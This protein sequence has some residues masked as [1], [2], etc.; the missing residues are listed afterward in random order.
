MKIGIDGRMIGE[1]MHGIARYTLN[2]LKGILKIDK[3]NQYVLLITDKFP[4]RQYMTFD[5]LRYIYMKSPF[6]SLSEP[7]ELYTVIRRERFELFHSPSF[8]PPFYSKQPFLMTIHDMSHLTYAGISRRLYYKFIIKPYVKKARKILTVSEFSRKEICKAFSLKDDKVSVV[9]NGV[10]D[11]FKPFGIEEINK[12]KKRYNLPDRFILSIGNEK[13]H[14]NFYLLLKAFKN[15]INDYSLVL[16]LSDKNPLIKESIKQGLGRRVIF[17]GYIDDRDLPLLYNASS[18][19]VFI[20]LN[21]GFGLPPLEAM[22]SGCPSV[23]SD[24]SSLPEICGDA[25]YYVDPYDD[26]S[27][28]TGINKTIED[29][30]LRDRLIRKGLE[31]AKLFSWEKASRKIFDFYQGNN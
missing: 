13:I 26:I 6:V 5:N 25:A 24:A 8:I 3:Y 18:V 7:L 9:Y 16:N 30:E 27:I 2:M 21:E 14:K 10:E 19:F 11:R 1:K 17:L 29:L 22:S 15:V 4:F 23:V 12:I 28:A 31:R 20:S